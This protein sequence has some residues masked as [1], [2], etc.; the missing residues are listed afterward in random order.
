MLE[1]LLCFQKSIPSKKFLNLSNFLLKKSEL[2][3]FLYNRYYQIDGWD[4]LNKIS[5]LMKAIVCI[6]RLSGVYLSKIWI[7]LSNRSAIGH[8]KSLQKKKKNLRHNYNLPSN[9]Y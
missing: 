4:G 8:R 3:F 7:M 2:R 9:R 1:V 5:M 6:K